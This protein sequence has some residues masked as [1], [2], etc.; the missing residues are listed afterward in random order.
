MNRSTA[1]W[2]KARASWSPWLTIAGFFLGLFACRQ[3]GQWCSERNFFRDFQRFSVGASPSAHFYPTSAQMLALV[4]EQTRSPGNVVV[5]VGG[6]SIFLGVGQTLDDLWSDE[7]QRLLGPGFSVVN[8][9]QRSSVITGCAQ[10][11]AEALLK[12]GEKVIY[13]A[14]TA[15]SSCGPADGSEPY[16]YLYWDARGHDR[17]F[18]YTPRNQ[19]LSLPDADHEKRSEYRIRA[20]LNSRLHFEELWTTLAYTTVSTVWCDYVRGRMFMPRERMPDDET[21]PEPLE[22]RFKSDE[23]RLLEGLRKFLPSTSV[24]DAAGNRVKPPPLWDFM[25]SQIEAAFPPQMRPHSLIVVVSKCPYYIH[26]LSPV[27]QLHFNAN[28]HFT[29]ELFERHGIRSL[30]IGHD[31]AYTD[32]KDFVH[33]TPSGGN[34]LAAALAPEIKTMARRL[35][36]K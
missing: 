4:R 25:E 2:E 5:I 15:S 22:K 29:A 21:L 28:L 35:Y 14:N 32:F 31:F 20:W 24:V 13:V 9:A 1:F 3:A 27:E 7:L 10:S 34:K 36:P 19:Q 16:R 11:I 23:A 17:L 18:D 12:N 6:S 8:L 26:K 30:A 33:L